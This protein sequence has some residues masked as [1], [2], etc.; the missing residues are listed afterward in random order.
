MVENGSNWQT[1]AL[2]PEE[3][4]PEFLALCALATSGSLTAQEQLRLREHLSRCP[5]CRRAMAQYEAIAGKVFPALAQQDEEERST[6]NFPE[7]SLED[8]EASLFTR[9]EEEESR[10]RPWFPVDPGSDPSSDLDSSEVYYD[11]GGEALWRHLWWQ[12]AAGVALFAALGFGLYH[13]GISRGTEVAKVSSPIA[14]PPATLGGGASPGRESSPAE[15]PN[16]HDDALAQKDAL[17]REQRAELEKQSVELSRLKTAQTEMNGELSAAAAAADQLARE[18]TSLSQ[19]LASAQTSI[20]DFQQKLAANSDQSAQ[21][22]AQLS[23]L[24]AKIATL[25]AG[26]RDREEEVAREQEMLTHD[27][28]IRDLMGAR[29]LYIA[30]VYDVAKTGDTEKPFGRVFYTKGKSLIFYAYDLDQKAGIQTAST[31]EAWGRRGP[32]SEQAVRLGI[33][34]QDNASKKRWVVKSNDPK[35]LAQIDAVFV[36]VEPSGGSPH[37]SG[38]PFLFAYLKIDS[39]H[40]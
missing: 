11:T 10:S 23:D 22:K 26:L 9:L 39:N 29:D 1:G 33:L 21:S 14:L 13:L 7:W 32:N 27:R 17:I 31:F 36:T 40:P 2:P 34:F 4:H 35:T 20:A 37:P 25:S 5:A 8:A 30:E 28:D 18:R 19:Q 16:A 15:A 6:T 12:F 38:K 3:T 24:E